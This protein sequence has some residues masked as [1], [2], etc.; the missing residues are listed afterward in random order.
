ME[1]L[2][3]VDR[4]CGRDMALGQGDTGQRFTKFEVSRIS[5]AE[6][7]GGARERKRRRTLSH[8]Q[9]LSL[10][11]RFLHPEMDKGEPGT[12]VWRAVRSSATGAQ[13]AS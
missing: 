12:R 11:N 10:K 13:G 7:E 2:T 1:F 8:K 6:L 4:E 3:A 5:R 9:P